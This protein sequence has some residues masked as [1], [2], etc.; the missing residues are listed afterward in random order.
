MITVLS[1]ILCSSS[2]SYPCLDR[3]GE[4]VLALHTALL[5]PLFSSFSSYPFYPPFA[6]VI[7]VGG[8][9]NNVTNNIVVVTSIFTAIVVT[10]L[11]HSGYGTVRL[12]LPPRCATDVVLITD[13]NSASVV[14]IFDFSLSSEANDELVP[15]R[16]HRRLSPQL[17]VLNQPPQKGRL[18]VMSFCHKILSCTV[19]H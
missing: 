19:Q 12:S 13:S 3:G 5:L 7:V 14:V 10:A 1:M 16:A 6:A 8:S 11:L 9:V 18:A 2:S 4:C 17:V 15:I